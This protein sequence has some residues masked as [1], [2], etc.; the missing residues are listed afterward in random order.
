MADG[1]EVVRGLPQRDDVTFIGL[2]LNLRGFERAM[3]CNI[4]EINCAVVAPDTFNRCNQGATTEETM[5]VIKEI[6]REI[7]AA[8]I[9]G[10]PFVPASTGNV[11]TED[12]L[13]MIHRMGFETSIGINRIIDTAKWLKS[14]LGA[15]M[16]A[17]LPEPGCFLP[18]ARIS[19]H[20][21]E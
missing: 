20:S 14:P 5:G 17:M 8:S 3:A 21:I 12:L 7:R 15:S 13:Y 2:V 16:P 4:D 1:E 11:T 6:T 9:D 19:H 18:L 10:C